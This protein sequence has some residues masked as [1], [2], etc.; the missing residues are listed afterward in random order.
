ME[1]QQKHEQQQQ[2]SSALSG[3]SLCTLISSMGI[4]WETELKSKIL[5]DEG[6]DDREERHMHKV[7]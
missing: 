7:T 5:L 3:E 6:E 1:W 2:P 4:L